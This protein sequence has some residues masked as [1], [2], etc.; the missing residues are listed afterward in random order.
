MNDSGTADA[1]QETSDRLL[2]GHSGDP[3]HWMGT[4]PHAATLIAFS[5]VR[6][7]HVIAAIT[8]KRWGC[9]Y[10]GRKKISRLAIKT[11]AAKPNRLITLTIDPKRYLSPREAYDAT[12]RKLGEL[13]KQLRETL[14]EFEYM[15]VLEATRK[16]WPHYHLVARCPY[17]PQTDLS[18]RWA[19]LV[20]APICDIRRIDRATD[21]YWYVVKYLGKQTHVP[22]TTRRISWSRHFFVKENED[23]PPTFGLTEKQMHPI[24][25]ARYAETQC[26]GEELERL[27]PTLWAFVKDQGTAGHLGRNAKEQIRRDHINR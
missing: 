14:K 17:L 24:H 1:G 15:R 23:K 21:A 5:T 10:C 12:R 13:A 19:A 22:W 7:Q 3:Y 8:C 9:A 2:V 26:R 18:S 16:G 4:C 20:G 6:Q 11:R 25:P 27:T